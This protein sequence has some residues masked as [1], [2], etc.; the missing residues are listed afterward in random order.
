MPEGFHTVHGLMLHWFFSEESEEY[1]RT[2]RGRVRLKG[3]V[4]HGI[5]AQ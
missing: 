1:E 3:S 5:K 4:K 2:G